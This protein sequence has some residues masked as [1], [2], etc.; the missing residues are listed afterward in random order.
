MSEQST[1]WWALVASAV[2]SVGVG[3]WTF[4][5]W[6]AGRQD[7]R[8]ERGQTASERREELRFR[9]AEADRVTAAAINARLL[10]D[11]HRMAAERDEETARADAWERQ[12]RDCYDRAR[13]MRHAAMNARHAASLLA[14]RLKIEAPTWAE[15]L[16]LPP[17][18]P[19][20]Q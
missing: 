7:R 15:S 14:A 2:P 5:Q 9:D 20:A 19:P 11:Y 10:A 12:A 17:I 3:V 16:D 6:W 13:D 18:R 4:M 1:P 8:E